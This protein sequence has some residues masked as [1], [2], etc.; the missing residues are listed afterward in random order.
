MATLQETGLGLRAA[1][2]TAGAVTTHAPDTAVVRH[3][4]LAILLALGVVCTFDAFIISALI[5]PIK[6]ELALT[7]ERFG[8]IAAAFTAAGVIGAP[9]FGYVAGRYGRKRA[10]IVGAVL[11]SLAS[12][13]GALASGV[14]GLMLWRALTGFGEAAYQGLAP[15]WL[16]DLYDRR[17]RNFVFS[18]FMVRNK[19]GSALG[20]ALG[21][22]LAARY[23]WRAA[24]LVSGIPGLI[25]AATLLLLPEPEPGASD[26]ESG[27]QRRLSFGTQ[28]GVLKVPPYVAH[29]A[30]LAFFY[31]GTMTAQMWAPAYLHREFGLSNLEASGFMAAVL[32]F[33]A[34]V[35]LIGGFIA[36]RALARFA[37]GLTW[38]LATTSWLAAASFT[39]AYASHDLVTA[40]SFIILAVI[41]FGSTAGSLTTLLVEHVPAVLRA[42]AGAIGAL[43]SAAISGAVAPWLLGHLS[44]RYGLSHAIFLGPASYALAGLIW[45]AAALTLFRK[46]SDDRGSDRS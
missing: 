5:T 46:N 30:A 8:L 19:I 36:G 33:T 31:S 39:V 45:L 21:A 22:W 35:G 25:L 24:F 11:W 32:L 41:A 43:V 29:L 34:P 4:S 20:L 12:S 16:S 17:W 28:L 42:S 18:L 23:D 37:T 3:A 7:D 13:G 40:K 26:G 38:A 44:D 27:G 14:A 6:A 9:L 2:R 10:L 1:N 15:S